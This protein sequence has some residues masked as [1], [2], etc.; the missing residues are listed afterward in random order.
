MVFKIFLF[1]N[2]SQKNI[3]SWFV[4]LSFTE[5][6]KKRGFVR[7]SD[8]CGILRAYDSSIMGHNR[9]TKE[10]GAGVTSG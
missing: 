7:T 2:L 8:F 10:G 6:V 9:V 5:I 4:C 3:D 1:T